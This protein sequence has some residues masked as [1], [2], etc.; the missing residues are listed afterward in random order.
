MSIPQAIDVAKV[1]TNTGGPHLVGGTGLISGAVGA[2]GAAGSYQRI[3]S[4]PVVAESHGI[5]ARVWQSDSGQ[6]TMGVGVSRSQVHWPGGSTTP[7]YAGGL[8]FNYKF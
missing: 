8:S 5:G 2:G 7:S 6:A 1:A 4:G 3:S